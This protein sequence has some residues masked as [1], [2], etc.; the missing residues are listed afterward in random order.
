ML[1]AQHHGDGAGAWQARVKLAQLR[2]TL[3][4][5]SATVG[6][7]VL[8]PFL[9]QA[10]QASDSWSGVSA[11]SLSPTSTMGTAAGHTPA[12]MADSSPDT[13]YW[14]AAPPQPGDSFG[15]SLGDG[16]PVD[17][18]TVRMGSTDGTGDPGSDAAA[19]KDDYLH[20]GVLE[21]ATGD[22]S[23]KQLL[24]VHNQKTV[25]A[26][27]PDGVLVTAIRL[28]ATA[29][30]Q[31]AV[32]VRDFSV[33]APGA[34]LVTVSGG[35]A[36]APGSSAA[37]VLDGDPDTAY[38]AAAAPTA[39]DTPLTVDLGD[40][41]PLDRITVLTDPTVKATAT[42]EI[43]KADGS[44]APVGTLNPGYNELP[45]GGQP[46]GA[47]RLTWAPG[48]DA[49]V[50]NQIVPWYADTPIARLTLANPELDVTA[51]AAT[52]AST[53]AVVDAVRP[54]GATGE[55]RAE[56]PAG[57]PGLTVTPAPAPGTPGAPVSVPRGGRA[58]TTVQVSAAATTPSGTYQVPVDFTTNG[59]TVHQTLQVHV[60][61]PTGGPDLALTATAGSSGDD[62][63]KTPASAI[64]D[65]NAATR[66]ASPAV[67]NA[68]V[69]LKL[70][71]P[72]RLGAAVLHWQAAFASAYQV[73]TSPDG[74]TWTT[75]ATMAGHGGTETVHFDA[76]NTLYLRMQGVSRATKYGYSL[77]GIEA[78]AVTDPAAPATTVP[79]PPTAPATPAPGAP[80]PAPTTSPS[81]VP[82]APGTAA[83]SAPP[84]I[85]PTPS[86]QPTPGAGATTIPG[87]PTPGAQAAQ[88]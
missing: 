51:G 42:V 39:T 13:F 40:T 27:L 60:V 41:R 21:Y 73:Q 11:G 25:A 45:T 71:Q 12:L 34:A 1:V 82:A 76:P 63:P 83:P 81:G 62:S 9:N 87:L 44:W 23:W 67:D 49:P 15:V 18:V 24:K 72:T 79:T 77:F 43:R 26:K 37:A 8:D 69:Q 5:G 85:V 22:G 59:V 10:L 57:V 4:Q 88:R 20:D 14:G 65:G 53:Q 55:I 28:R 78:Y 38:R 7:G 75:V 31:T 46:V 2:D 33:S 61:P 36:P 86:G 56:L 47:V 58:S 50:V 35:P 66:W 68:W 3:A 16:R 48:G 32:A 64:A 70:A 74:V 19:A 54:E 6:T 80:V 30:Q 29:T 17:T 84:V 52:P